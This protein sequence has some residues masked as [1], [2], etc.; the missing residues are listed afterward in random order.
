MKKYLFHIGYLA[1]II[2]LGTFSIVLYQK[3]DYLNWKMD[4]MLI[5]VNKMDDTL[6]NAEKEAQ[7]NA[8]QAVLE[9]NRAEI[10]KENAIIAQTELERLKKKCGAK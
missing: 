1:V 2:C 6:Q 7:M 10:E 3:N 8:A 4:G 5:Q 9:K